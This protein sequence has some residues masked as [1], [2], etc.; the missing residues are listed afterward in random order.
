L[1][2]KNSQPRRE[3][4]WKKNKARYF[5]YGGVGNVVF[6]KAKKEDKND[7]GYHR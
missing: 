4:V 1:L 6:I 7:K 2:G 3:E 5:L